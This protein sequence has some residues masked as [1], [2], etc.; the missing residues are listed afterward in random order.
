MEIAVYSELNALFDDVMW[1]A[2]ISGYEC[3]VYL[4]N[5]GIGIEIDGVYWHSRKP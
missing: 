1:R 3:D 2:K 5:K 4:R